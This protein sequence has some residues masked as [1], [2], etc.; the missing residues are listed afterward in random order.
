MAEGGYQFEVQIRTDDMHR[1][2]E[3][4]IAAHWKYKSGGGVNTRDEQR[5]AWM[6]QLVEWQREMRDPADFL[7]TLKVDLYPDEV[8]AFTPKG[9]VV[10]LPRD[11][12][13]VDFAYAVHTGSWARVHGREGECGGWFRCG[14]G[15]GTATWWRW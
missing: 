12:S 6:R 9:K 14:R 5:L 2:A 11:A 7:S 10:P 1:T 8:Y 13:P 3:E 15:C 4:G